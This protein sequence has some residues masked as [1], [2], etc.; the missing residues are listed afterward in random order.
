MNTRTICCKLITTPSAEDAFEETSQLFAEACN[1][2]LKI[3]VAEKT[4]NAIKLHKLCYTDIRKLFGLSA[5]LAVRSIRRVAS[6]MT[7]LKG[8][9]KHPKEFRPKSIDYDARIFSYREGSVSLTTTK[10][11][12]QTPMLLG[13]YQKKALAGQNPTSATVIKK[14]KAWYIHIVIEFE[15]QLKG[16]EGVL[17]IDLGLSNIATASTGLRIEGKARQDFKKRRA[18]IRAS[19]Q[20]KGK[21]S[22]K[23]VLK[24]LSG[25]ENRKIRHENHVL[26]KQLVEEA[27]R[28]NCGVIRME[29]LKDIRSKTKTWNK[30][31]NRMMAGW[32]FYQLQQF[33]TYKAAALGIGVELINP[34]YTSQTCHQCLKLGSR[35]RESFNCLTCGEE[36]ADVNA[37]RVIALGGAAC[38]PARISTR[39]GS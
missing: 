20:S 29:R 21:K 22:T 2:V 32:S 28:H 5:N 3:A 10:G 38:K 1:H 17:G 6:C 19:L 23:K 15:G 25:Y 33:V 31:L 4:H 12:L 18:K 26:S 7:Q 13:E 24:R 14:H 8:K 27:K 35:D 11:R 30:H 16:G 39:K 36:H 34:A 37:S 9:R